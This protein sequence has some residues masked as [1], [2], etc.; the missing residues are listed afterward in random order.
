M[1]F[2]YVKQR[3]LDLLKRFLVNAGFSYVPDSV[4]V[5]IPVDSTKRQYEE[6][7]DIVDI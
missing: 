6:H 3:N 2:R 4:Q 1:W 5:N 7:V